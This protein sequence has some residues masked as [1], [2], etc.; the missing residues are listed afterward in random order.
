MGSTREIAKP[1]YL[2]SQAQHYQDSLVSEIK[3]DSP[4]EEPEE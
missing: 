4:P 1:N 3:E 2:S